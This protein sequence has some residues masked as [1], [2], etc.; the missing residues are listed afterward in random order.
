MKASFLS[1]VVAVFALGLLTVPAEA[2]GRKYHYHGWNHGSHY[3]RRGY[4]GPRFYRPYSRPIYYYPA[5]Y[6]YPPPVYYGP[7]PVFVFGFGF[8]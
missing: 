4:Y 6:Y 8:H 2:G 1:I 3:G 7:A 5:P